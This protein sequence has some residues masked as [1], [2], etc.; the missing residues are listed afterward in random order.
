L[1]YLTSSKLVA[2]AF[3]SRAAHHNHAIHVVLGKKEN[4]DVE[5]L[6]LKLDVAG[7]PIGWVSQEEGALLYCR[8]QVAWEAGTEVLRLRGGINRTTGR[9]SVLD[10]N[11]IVATRG[12]DRSASTLNDVPALTNAGLFQRDG[13]LCLYCGEELPVRLLTRDHVVPLSR[14]GE[15]SWENVVS[16]C[17]ACN[18]RKA[19]RLLDEIGMKLIAVPYAPNRAEGLI[20]ANRRILA[21]QMMFLSGRV[22]RG[23]RMRRG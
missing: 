11:S 8:D 13:Y 2:S 16:S 3:E 22:G 15:D 23:S 20:L 21:D 10:I 19:D 12:S 18:H 1:A 9:R 4:N 7:I 5:S 14:G 17:R 6:I